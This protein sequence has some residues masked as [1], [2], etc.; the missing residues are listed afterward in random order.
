[1]SPSNSELYQSRKTG[2]PEYY[3]NFIELYWIN[4]SQLRLNS[5]IS[6]VTVAFSLSL[7]HTHAHTLSLTHTRQ[8]GMLAYSGIYKLA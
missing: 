4:E 6:T 7:S 1:M 2:G 3:L 8:N 5:M